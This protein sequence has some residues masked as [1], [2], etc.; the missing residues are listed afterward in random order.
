MT[1]RRTVAAVTGSVLIVMAG[2]VLLWSAVTTSTAQLSAST[3]GDGFFSAGTVELDQPETRVSLLFDADGLFP[4]KVVTSC[5]TLAYE[6][7]I[8]ADIRLHASRSGGTGL[9]D[10][11][12]LRLSALPSGSC[13]NDDNGTSDDPGG[14]GP[15]DGNLPDAALPGL[16][17]EPTP[18]DGLGGIAGQAADET[19][20]ETAGEATADDG[21]VPVFVGLLGDLWRSHP[22]YGDGLVLLDGAEDGD[23][24]VL[25]AE[26]EMV[27]GDEAQGLTTEFSIIIE[28]RP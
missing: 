3:S 13:P 20:D 16:V 7:S 22:D 25:G 4:G 27:G 1:A 8:P 24:L 10:H 15:T 2:V 12:E 19:A 21:S 23:R 5:V 18:F 28:A 11:V 9:E 26:I 14:I 17:A 6:G